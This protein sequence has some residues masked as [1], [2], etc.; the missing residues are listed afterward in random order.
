MTRS[1]PLKTIWSRSLGATL[2]P[3]V[4]A[5]YAGV[6]LAVASV[7]SVVLVALRELRNL[8]RAAAAPCVRDLPARSL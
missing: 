3:T 5:R 6:T 7:V 8:M 2:E 1:S 4:R